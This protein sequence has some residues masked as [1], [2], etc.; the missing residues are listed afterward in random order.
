VT[1]GWRQLQHQL[2]RQRGDV[3]LGRP[4]DP[5]DH[6]TIRFTIIQ[7]PLPDGGITVTLDHASD[8]ADLY[9]LCS[10]V[11]RACLDDD[12]HVTFTRP[13]PDPEPDPMETRS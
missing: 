13:P 3:L 7:L 4:T 2:L 1:L 11:A 6:A 8:L 10:R 12:D 5:D 9:D